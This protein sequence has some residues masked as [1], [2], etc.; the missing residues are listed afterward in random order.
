MTAVFE[1]VIAGVQDLLDTRQI[2]GGELTGFRLKEMIDTAMAPQFDEL[3]VTLKQVLDRGNN[4]LPPRQME[5]IYNQRPV[6]EV[7][8]HGGMFSRLPSSYEFPNAGV[9]DL[10][11]KWN[12]RDDVRD[13][14][15]L[16]TLHSKD[17]KFLDSKPKPDG[18]KRRASRL[19]YSDMKFVCER[20][21]TAARKNGMDPSDGSSENIRI[22]YQQ[23][24]PLISEGL[25]SGR[26]TQHKWITLSDKLR[27]K[28]K[29]EK[30]EGLFE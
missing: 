4:P 3:K 21:E 30:E 26:G 24:W 12:I 2:G 17:F 14:P 6:N 22:I 25:G 10:W 1:K 15:P 13:I 29:R 7:R 28:M 11:I 18:S 19:I 20:I 27:K 9:Y 16:K 23:V 8:M 5:S